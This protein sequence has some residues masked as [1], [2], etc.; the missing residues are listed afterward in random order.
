MIRYSTVA[1]VP[2]S[3]SS[4]TLEPRAQGHPSSTFTARLRG[5][6]G[7]GLPI[8]SSLAQGENGTTSDKWNS[9]PL[10]IPFTGWGYMGMNRSEF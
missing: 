6:D 9:S 10:P 4:D 1:E 7:F 8:P 5:G 2:N 3:P